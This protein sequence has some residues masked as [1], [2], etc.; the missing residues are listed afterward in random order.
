MTLGAA[1]ILAAALLEDD[2][3]AGAIGVEQFAD[4]LGTVNHRRANG[5]AFITTKHEHGTERQGVAGLAFKLLDTN[6]VAG[7]NAVLLT[8]GLDHCKH[9]LCFL[10]S[11]TS[12]AGLPGIGAAL[13]LHPVS[14]G[15][16]FNNY[17]PGQRAA[18]TGAG[19]IR[20]PWR[21]SMRTQRSASI[22]C[23]A[24]R[25]GAPGCDQRHQSR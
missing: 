19:V 20:T 10:C 18:Q 15:R 8:A 17:Q 14:P 25:M 9:D 1:V 7:C 21:E 13:F 24:D 4:H 3:L 12:P 23:R 6:F 5:H 2:D 22:R 11:A 16:C